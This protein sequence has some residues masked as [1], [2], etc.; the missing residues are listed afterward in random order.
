MDVPRRT[1]ADTRDELWQNGAKEQ[2]RMANSAG[3][4][5]WYEL[6]TPDPDAIAPFYATV[7]GWTIGKSSPDQSGGKDYRMIGRSDG[8]FAGGVLGLSDDM[9]QHGARPVWLGYLATPNVDSEVA[10]IVA[11]GGK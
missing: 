4:F 10:A 11:E 3:S 2:R 7:I 6:M 9:Q 8:G 5:I 1:G